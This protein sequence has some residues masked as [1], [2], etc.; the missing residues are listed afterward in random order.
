MNNSMY[1][2]LIQS[3]NKTIPNECIIEEKTRELSKKLLS[4]H[5]TENDSLE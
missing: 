2:Q 3:Q 5:T 4:S 1:K